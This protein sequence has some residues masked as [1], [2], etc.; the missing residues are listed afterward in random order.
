[1]FQIGVLHCLFLHIKIYFI[2]KFPLVVVEV[3]I[4]VHN[5]I[6]QPSIK[7][8]TNKIDLI[9]IRGFLK[10]KMTWFHH[11]TGEIFCGPKLS[12]ITMVIF[13]RRNLEW[14]VGWRNL[15]ETNIPAQFLKFND[16]CVTLVHTSYIHHKIRMQK[17]AFWLK[18]KNLFLM[19]GRMNA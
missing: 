2:G 1:M 16:P 5:L 18:R 17:Y 9:V 3:L 11:T 6:F 7:F 12:N 8:H 15:N 13:T 14:C 19:L 4:F 10:I